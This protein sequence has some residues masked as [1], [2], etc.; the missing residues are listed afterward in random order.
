MSDPASGRSPL[1][2]AHHAP[3]YE[4]QALIRHYQETYSCRLVVMVDYLFPHSVTLFEETLYDA[5]PGEDLH[6]MLCTLGG[7]G[8]TA[9]RLVHQAQSRCKKLTAIVP[10]QAKSAGTLFVLGAD[11]I[12]MGPTSDL[13]PIDPQ[14][15]L[16]SGAF[17]SGKA[18]IAAVEDAERRIQ[19][20]PQTYP[21]HAS[22]LNDITALL[23]QQAKDAIARTDDQ[24]KEALACA[25]G[26]DENQIT[27]FASKL[28]E[29]LIKNPQSHG[30]AISVR[31]AKELGLPVEE[32]SG[33]EA[34]WQ[35]IWR[36][37]AKYAALDAQ[38]VYEGQTA[39]QIFF[40]PPPAST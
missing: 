10:D 2:E 1:Y 28:R 22:L 11:R 24:L 16:P 12:L 39:S 29:P 31:Y 35:S 8:E 5:N 32:A 27:A 34:Q 14:F 6:V 33:S 17:A 9:L 3:R 37:W 13:G 38:A 19:A 40:R 25:E 23:V 20:N 26:R 15:R 30:T 18:I 36:M 21:L 4:R 7:D